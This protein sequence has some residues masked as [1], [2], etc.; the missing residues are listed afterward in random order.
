LTTNREYRFLIHD[1]DSIYSQEPD[2]AVRA[3]GVK[4]LKTPFRA[5][6]AYAYGERL[7]GSLRRGCLDFLIP[8]SETHFRRMV[9]DWQVHYQ[10]SSPPF[11]LGTR[12]PRAEARLSG[13]TAK[14]TTSNSQGI[15]SESQ[16]DSR[17][18][19][20]GVS[21]GE[22]RCLRLDDKAPQGRTV[23]D[24]RGKD[25]RLKGTSMKSE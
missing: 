17:R 9:K 21:A 2:L 4:I 11:E 5:P 23:F 20:S 14:T 10:P 24:E 25:Q 18:P 16:T 12:A 7:I 13:T 6:Q 3:L 8:M 22:N 1:R 15:S 19:R